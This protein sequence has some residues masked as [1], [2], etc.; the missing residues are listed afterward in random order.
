[1]DKNSIDYLRLTGRNED[2]IAYI[3]SY[4]KTQGLYRNYEDSSS[5][6]IFN[7]V[8]EIDLSSIIPALAGP[9]RPHDLIP[10]THMKNDFQEVKNFF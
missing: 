8:L 1:M 3:E 6:P 5:D 9:K 7:D 10:L 2:K 4:L